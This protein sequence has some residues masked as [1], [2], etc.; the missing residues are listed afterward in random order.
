MFA[1]N[2]LFK[3]L[4]LPATYTK[5]PI[6]KN[7]YW[8]ASS[9]KT[10]KL[11]RHNYFCYICTCSLHSFDFNSGQLLDCYL[12]PTTANE[13]Y[14]TRKAMSNGKAIPFPHLLNIDK[15]HMPKLMNKRIWTF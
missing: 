2:N 10:I 6:I 4:L 14:P 12:S 8:V 7:V 9:L 13:Y 1:K 15:Y 5:G 11:L 3:S